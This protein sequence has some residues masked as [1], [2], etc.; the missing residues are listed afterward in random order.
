MQP[1]SVVKAM[2]KNGKDVWQFKWSEKG[3][4]GK[5]IYRK[6][7]IGTIDQYSDA[8]EARHSAA[9]NGQHRFP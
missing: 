3:G 4:D 8:A 2:R 5:R 7:V 9:G 6:R 1:V